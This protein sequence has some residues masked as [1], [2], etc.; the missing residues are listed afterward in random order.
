MFLVKMMVMSCSLGIG[1]N[2]LYCMHKQEDGAVV[3]QRQIPSAME[4]C[5]QARK[6]VE[7][8]HLSHNIEKDDWQYY[9][10][11]TVEQFKR[12]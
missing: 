8:E 1:D 5:L 7:E 2:R 10:Y 9:A 12:G 11:C 3:T 4:A 6:K